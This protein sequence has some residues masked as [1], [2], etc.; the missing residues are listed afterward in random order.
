VLKADLSIRGTTRRSLPLGGRLATYAAAATLA[1]AALFVTTAAGPAAGKGLPS[2]LADFTHCPVHVKGVATCVF[3]STTSTT[4]EIGSTTVSS[5]SPTT[6]SFGLK[7][8]RSGQATVVLPDDGSQALQAPAIPLPGGLTGIP[9]QDSGPLSV[10]ATPQLVGL[11]LMNLANLLGA[12]GPGLTLPID[13][14]V[15]TPTGALGSDC[16]IGDAASPVTLELTTGTTDPPGPN[17]PITGSAGTLTSTQQG[18]LTGS[19]MTLVDNA[20]AVPGAENCGTDGVL[21]EV[22]DLDKSLP[23][24]AGSNTAILMGSSYIAPAKLVKKYLR[25]TA[26]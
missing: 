10:T 25:Q 24:A 26:G 14:L 21:D 11:P 22:L 5:T 13:V 20:F 23:S 18:I 4:F 7:Y 6:I 8:S 2:I 9:G 12:N 19:G 3:S 16:T 1:G 15:S 17:T